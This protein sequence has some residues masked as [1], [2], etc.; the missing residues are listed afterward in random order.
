MG[1]PDGGTWTPVADLMGRSTA[2]L[3]GSFA[4]YTA[5]KS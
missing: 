2:A 3:T 5:S 4:S 1:W